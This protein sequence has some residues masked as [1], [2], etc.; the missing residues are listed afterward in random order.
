MFSGFLPF[1]AKSVA[2]PRAK[3][4]GHFFFIFPVW[5]SLSPWELFLA[6]AAKHTIGVFFGFSTWARRAFVDFP[7]GLFFLRLV[8]LP[9]PPACLYINFTHQ[10]N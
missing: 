6:S 2:F 9:L 4:F 5:L 3:F 10:L 1:P 8:V 7:S